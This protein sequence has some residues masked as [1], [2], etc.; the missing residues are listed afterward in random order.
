MIKDLSGSGKVRPFDVDHQI[1]NLGS[2]GE[3]T[4]EQFVVKIFEVSVLID[5]VPFNTTFIN[6]SVDG[7][8]QFVEVVG[9]NFGG[10]TDGNTIGTHEQ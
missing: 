10:H 6:K 3:L 5:P 8:G 9:W 4:D 7:L 1:F 2:G